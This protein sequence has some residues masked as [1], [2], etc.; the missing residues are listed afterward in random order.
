MDSH[1]STRGSPL[2]VT[3]AVCALLL[4]LNMAGSMGAQSVP[5]D[6]PLRLQPLLVEASANEEEDGYD[7]TGMGATEAETY[8]APFSNEI[9]WDELPEDDINVDLDDELTAISANRAELAASG[10]RLRLRGFP[11]PQL[12]DSYSQTGVPEILNV[13]RAQIIQGPLTAVTGRGAPGGIRNYLSYRPRARQQ[14]E[15]GFEMSDRTRELEME[16]TGPLSPK[17]AWQRT[18][19]EWEETDGPQTFAWEE[20]LEVTVATTVRPTRRTSAMLQLDH[21]RYR[22]NPAPGVPEFRATADAPIVGP[23]RPLAFFHAHGPNA[24]VEK[25]VTSGTLQVES[26]LAPRLMLRTSLQSLRRELV[27]NRF[28]RGV[29]Q[30]DTGTFGGT[31]EPLH[32]EQPLSLLAGQVDLTSRFSAF[33]LE[34]KLFVAVESIRSRA[35]RLQ[36]ALTAEDRETLLPPDVRTFAPA[37]PNYFRP[38]YSPETYRRV[39]ADRDETTEYR[40]IAVSDRTAFANGRVVVTAGARF[41]SVELELEDRR[42]GAAFP[43]VKDRAEELTWHAGAN[44]VLVPGRV[45]AFANSSTAFEPSTRVDARTGRIQGNETTGGFELGFKGM[46]PRRLNYTLLYFDF[47]NENISR[48][49]PR[50][51]D[52]ILDPDLTEP[53]LLASG[54][55]AFRGGAADLRLQLTRQWRI[56]LRAGFT[57]ARTTRSPDVPEE[58][59]RPLVRMPRV[60]A[61]ISTRYAWDEGPL[62]GVSVGIGANYVDGFVARYADETRAHLAYPSVTQ[63]HAHVDYE[64]ERGRFEHEIGMR[65]R[66]LLDRDLLAALAQPGRDREISFEYELEF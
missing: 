45:L 54:E 44:V 42:S 48:R 9:I 29:Y 12:R 32:T 46:L 6:P 30:L 57:D 5:A 25:D 63:V 7:P 40:G 62:N 18:A 10:V 24:G 27:D 51:N 4:G 65:V 31:R 64:W 19:L 39:I 56:N 37:A 22:G 34:H 11:T 8:D 66:N 47:T 49:N 2:P 53:E 61:S 43:R 36:R 17:K 21:A 16:T 50:Y 3:W 15:L 33:G 59:G 55:E 23:Y 60:T 20:T 52:P 38:A 14:T 28:T 58:E 1:R 13:R 35:T 41:D 26:Q